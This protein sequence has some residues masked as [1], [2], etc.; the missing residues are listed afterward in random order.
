M[1]DVL[2]VTSIVLFRCSTNLEIRG[3]GWGGGGEKHCWAR[4]AQQYSKTFY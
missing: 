2:A 3:G 1:L 4:N